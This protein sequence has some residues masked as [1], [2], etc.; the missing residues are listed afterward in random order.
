VC[1]CGQELPVARHER[2]LW[3]GLVRDGGDG[4]PQLRDDGP[5]E[6]VQERAAED[7][8]QR[9]WN[10]RLAVPAARQWPAAAFSL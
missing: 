3:V 2:P 8:D 1:G 9:L 7:L 4:E 5:D 10:R 6:A